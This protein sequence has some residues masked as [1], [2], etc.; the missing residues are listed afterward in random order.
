MDDT[1]DAIAY[2][3]KLFKTGADGHGTDHALR[4]LGNAM[5]IAEGEKCDLQVVTLAALLHNVD[6]HKLFHT[7][8]NENARIISC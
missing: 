4:V 1:K 5:R 2:L 8:D 6:D 7:R 3:D